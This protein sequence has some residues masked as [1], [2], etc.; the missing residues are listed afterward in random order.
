MKNIN[1]LSFLNLIEH[2]QI[3]VIIYAWDTSIV[4][5]N[6]TGLAL[7]KLDY[8][9]AIGRDIY[10]PNWNLIDETGNILMVEDYPVNVVKQTKNKVSNKVLGIIGSAR[11]EINWLLTNA[12]FEGHDNQNKFIVMTISDISE[13]KQQFAFQDV[14]ENTQDMVVITDAKNIKYPDGPKI[15]Y[16][17]KAFEKLTGYRESEVIGETPRILQGNLTD[18]KSKRRISSALEQC[19][20]VTETLLNYDSKGRPYWVEM[21]IIPLK[22]KFSEVTHFA[23][24]QRDVSKSKFQT[25][26]LEKRNKDLKELKNNLE[27][28]VQERTFELQK[29]KSQLEKIAFFDPLTSIP[30]RR[31]FSDQVRKLESSCIRN[32]GILAFGLFDVDNFKKVNDTYGHNIGDC[33]LVSLAKLLNEILRI[34]DVFCRFG[35]EEF[36]FAVTLKESTHAERVANKLINAIRKIKVPID[37]NNSISITVSMG[38]NVLSPVGNTDI[39]DELKKADFAMYEAK[40]SGKDRYNIVFEA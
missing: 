30:N 11:G 10:D 29:T 14:V 16:V 34:D 12:Y 31:F 5:I 23:A 8:D 4:Y 19:E 35:G 3:G 9:Q 33:V 28:L 39:D 20:E 40:K 22:N 18:T 26:Q 2:T 37:D 7:L 21:N 27:N 36:A 1:N 25:E 15:V 13:A 17:N 24:I 32:K 38:L 6:P